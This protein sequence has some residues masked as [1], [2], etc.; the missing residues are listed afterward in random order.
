[1]T[2]ITG[3]TVTGLVIKGAQNTCR[4]KELVRVSFAAREVIIASSTQYLANLFS[5][6]SVCSS[7]QNCS[8]TALTILMR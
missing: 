1:M 4:T 6:I 3:A 7:I 5:A 8:K 2:A